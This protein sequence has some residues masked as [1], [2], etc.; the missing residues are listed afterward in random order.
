MFGGPKE[1]PVSG[2]QRCLKMLGE[3]RVF[4]SHLSSFQHSV[5]AGVAVRMGGFPKGA[6]R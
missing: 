3:A 5:R 6:G 4:D 2:S 1:E